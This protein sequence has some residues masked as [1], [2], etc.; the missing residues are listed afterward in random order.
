M[1][2][3]QPMSSITLATVLYLDNY[4]GWIYFISELSLFLYKGYGLYYP[5]EVIGLE[6]FGLVLFW[7][8]FSARI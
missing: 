1:S 2:E 5:T 7:I 4:Y 6:V 3:T 8:A